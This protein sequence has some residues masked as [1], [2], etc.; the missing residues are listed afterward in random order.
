VQRGRVVPTEYGAHAVATL[1]P[2]AVLR[3]QTPEDRRRE[4]ARLTAD[5]RVV[6]R[7]LDGRGAAQPARQSRGQRTPR[8][9][10]SR[11]KRPARRAP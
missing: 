8:A 3:Q 6:A 9:R 5:L 4:M 10:G 1:H 7:L 11:L 2:S